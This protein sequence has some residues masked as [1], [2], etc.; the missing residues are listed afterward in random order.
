MQDMLNAA[1][2]EAIW[3]VLLSTVSIQL[4]LSDDKHQTR[5]E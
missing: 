1:H 3:R 5:D 4:L 2:D